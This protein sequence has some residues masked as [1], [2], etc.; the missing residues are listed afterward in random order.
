MTLE[1]SIFKTFFQDGPSRV[2]L[3]GSVPTV[4]AVE[5][6]DLQLA[7]D[8]DAQEGRRPEGHQ[9]HH[10]ADQQGERQTDLQSLGQKDSQLAGTSIRIR[11]P[12]KLV[13]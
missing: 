6:G 9:T 11:K 3:P 2:P 5:D 8:P 13:K 10:A 12:K 1:T 7:P 4:R